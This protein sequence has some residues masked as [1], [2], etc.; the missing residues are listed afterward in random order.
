MKFKVGDKVKLREGL[1]PYRVYGGV[2]FQ[3]NMQKLYGNTYELKIH[4]SS[5]NWYVEGWWI[6]EAML[7]PA[8]N[9]T[10]V[11]FRRGKEVIALDKRT[12]KRGVAKCSPE[13][14]FDFM[15]GAKQRFERLTTQPKCK[16][17]DIVT[18]K[19][20]FYHH[21]KDGAKGI[22]TSYDE[23][24]GSYGVVALRKDGNRTT[25]QWLRPEHLEVVE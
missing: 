8:E 11:I 4:S 12:D 6:N 2:T 24:D 23:H 14:K 15:V 25:S 5:G 21:L 9:E 22:V 13:D 17:G 7:E 1:E 16:V 20:D 18:V 3:P 10:I 19:G